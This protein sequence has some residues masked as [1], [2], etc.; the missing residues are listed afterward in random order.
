MAYQRKGYVCRMKTAR[1]ATRRRPPQDDTGASARSRI[2]GAAFR[3]F[4]ERGFGATSML[5]IATRAKVSKRDLYAL[6]A[7]K[8][9]LLDDCIGERTRAMRTPLAPATVPQSRQ[10][11]AA[12]LVELGRT[13]LQTVSRDEVL[14]VY[15]LCIAESDRAPQLARMLDASGRAANHKALA[16]LLAQAQAR[17]LIGAADPTALATRFFAVLWDSLLMQLLLR[18]R[19]APSQDEIEARAGA[20]AEAI[21]SSAPQNSSDTSSR[22]RTSRSRSSRPA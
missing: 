18:T 11:L 8:Q 14:M 7:N 1:I 3:L 21:M 9:A 13:V 15:R 17:G 16:E 6:Y 5:E 19:A 22:C 12:L 4:F 10:A 2:V 20:A